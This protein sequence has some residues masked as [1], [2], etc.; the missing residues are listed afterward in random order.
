MAELPRAERCDGCRY[1]ERVEEGD[2]RGD[3]GQLYFTDEPEPAP[4]VDVGQCLRFPPVVSD[5]VIRYTLMLP[6]FKGKGYPPNSVSAIQHGSVFPFTMDSDW[7]G[8][9]RAKGDAK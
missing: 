1:W 3:E 4:L 8:E 5:E 7:C 9:W 6:L 2:L